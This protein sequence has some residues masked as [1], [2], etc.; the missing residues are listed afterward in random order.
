MI[1]ISFVPSVKPSSSPSSAFVFLSRFAFQ[2]L[3]RQGGR[4]KEDSRCCGV[5]KYR[6]LPSFAFFLPV[7][8]IV[9]V[10]KKEL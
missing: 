9:V 3:S 6:T 8:Y 10:V 4:P 2:F 7:S 1:F 5:L